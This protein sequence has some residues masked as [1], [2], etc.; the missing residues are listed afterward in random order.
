ME[1]GV[2]VTVE[3]WAVVEVG[4]AVENWAVGGG[5]GG[6]GLNG[7]GD[8]REAIECLVEVAKVTPT[9]SQGHSIYLKSK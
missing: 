4:V 3:G 7:G 9:L 6:Q 2:G 1:V 8:C 5:W